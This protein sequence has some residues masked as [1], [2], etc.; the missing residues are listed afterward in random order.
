MPKVQDLLPVRERAHKWEYQKIFNAIRD[1]KRIAIFRHIMPDP[2]CLGCQIGL[3][4]WIKDNFPDKEVVC[5]GDTHPTLIPK[6]FP[7]M[8]KPDNSFFEEP[9]L[10][11]IVDCSNG[12]RVADPRWKDASLK[13]KIDHHPDVDQFADIEVVDTDMVANSELTVNM[14]LSFGS[15]YDL[16]KEAATW[17]YIGV[18]ADSNRFMY[19]TSLHTFQIAEVLLDAGVDIQAAYNTLYEKQID[20]LKNTAYVLNHF[21]I[22]KHG[23]A[24]YILDAATQEKLNIT[25]ERGK[26]NVNLF[27]N[28]EGIG[29]WCSITEDPKDQCWR[30]SIRSKSVPINGVASMFEGGGHP[31]AA[32]AKLWSLDDLPRLIDELDKL[33]VDE[34]NY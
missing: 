23:V 26:D 33:F 29:A 8:D 25:V 20:D 7:E 2:D 10:A 16:T 3:K 12:N 11:I 31:N 32:G 18:V 22:S 28:V 21:N 5:L 15:Y 1:Y 6:V 34:E 13:I 9:F 27:Q 24:Y 14:L 17:F 4:T 30:V 19:N